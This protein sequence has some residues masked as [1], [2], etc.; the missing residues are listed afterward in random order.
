M[1]PDVKRVPMKIIEIDVKIRMPTRHMSPT[2]CRDISDH[3]V[4]RKRRMR[5]SSN[6]AIPVDTARKRSGGK[7]PETLCARIGTR[8]S[9]AHVTIKNKELVRSDEEVMEE[10]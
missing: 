9:I 4:R 3:C 2:P 7:I 6:A 1:M 8:P 10:A 5:K